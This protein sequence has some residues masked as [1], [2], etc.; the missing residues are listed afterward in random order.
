VLEIRF[1]SQA[2][3]GVGSMTGAALNL[4][5]D[6]CRN[7]LTLVDVGARWGAHDRWLPLEKIAEILCFEPDEE[8]CRRLEASRRPNIRYL[9][10]GLS[11]SN[12]ER[13][14]FITLEPA[15]SS[16]FEPIRALHEHYPGLAIVRPMSKI[17]MSCQR[18]DDVLI[19]QGI[20]V[21]S[22]LKLDTQGSELSIMRGGERA[23]VYR[24][25]SL[26]HRFEPYAAA[27]TEGSC[28]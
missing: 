17:T 3:L 15:C 1:G 2:Q 12:G 21:V 9:P 4:L 8:E 27:T 10:I 20:G 23:L 16:N 28:F 25:Q 11:D 7:R 26:G 19:E 18:L 22:A 14:L 24:P 13:D 6:H 5:L